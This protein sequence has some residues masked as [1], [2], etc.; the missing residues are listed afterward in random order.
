MIHI[1]AVHERLRD[2][3]HVSHERLVTEVVHERSF[4]G[5]VQ[6]MNGA[7]RDVHE[8]HVIQ[9][10]RSVEVASPVLLQVSMPLVQDVC[11]VVML[12]HL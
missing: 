11:N 7:P 5:V 9:L 3:M 6:V 8:L 10:F 12:Y 4:E 2:D 1:E